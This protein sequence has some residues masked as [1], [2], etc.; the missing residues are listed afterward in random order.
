MLKLKLIYH[1]ATK[2]LFCSI[3]FF[4][5]SVEGYSQKDLSRTYFAEGVENILIDGNGVH[6]LKIHASNVEYISVNVHL[7]GETSEEI[8][9]REQIQGNQLSLGFGSWPLAKAYNDKLSAH[10]IISVEVLITIPENLFVSIASNTAGV[11]AKGT[12]RSLHIDIE[13]KNCAVHTFNGDATLKTNVGNIMVLIDNNTTVAE[14]ETTY[15]TVKTNLGAT[16]IFTIFAESVHG[17]I[18]LQQTQ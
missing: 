1:K 8:V 14:A 4:V 11:Y 6:T 12:F 16:G 7:E 17:D 13:D 9:I 2:Y 3:F 18:T 10:K 15:G 5:I